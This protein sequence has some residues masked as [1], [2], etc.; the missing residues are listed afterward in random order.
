MGYDDIASRSH[1]LSEAQNDVRWILLIRDEVKHGHEQN[2]DRLLPIDM[3]VKASIVDDV[4]WLPYVTLDYMDAMQERIVVREYLGV[5]VDS[6]DDRV[7]VSVPRYIGDV[8]IVWNSSSD[9]DELLD[10]DERAVI[11]GP[12][13]E[14]PVIDRR[15]SNGRCRV[16]LPR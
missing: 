12:S 3:R 5:V 4:E 15:V 8:R 10:T 6:D 13:K 1:S 11:N 7:G 16:Q 14:A 9:V 2:G